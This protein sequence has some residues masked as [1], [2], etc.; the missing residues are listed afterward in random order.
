MDVSGGFAGELDF[1]YL[2]IGSTA[3]SVAIYG[4]LDGTGKQLANQA[5]KLGNQEVFSNLIAV[6]F[7]GTAHSVVFSGGNNQL[8]FDN[9]SFQSV[10]EPG[11]ALLLATGLLSVFFVRG[12][13]HARSSLR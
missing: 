1:Y 12:A 10:P 9:I 7:A 3:S 6:K 4:G 11:S 5:L 8:A 13:R 2:G